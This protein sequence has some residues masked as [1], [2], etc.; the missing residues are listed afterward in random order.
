MAL[1]MLAAG[2][3]KGLIGG[4]SAKKAG[5]ALVKTKEPKIKKAVKEEVRTEKKASFTSVTEASYKKVSQQKRIS[6]SAFSPE[7]TQAKVDSKVTN[8]TLKTQLDN[9]IENTSKLDGVYKEQFKE[10]KDNAR[11]KDAALA[12]ERAER[13]ERK[14][15]TTPKKKLF[16]GVSLKGPTDIMD[17][18]GK[19]LLNTLLGGLA[20][21]T[22]NNLDKIG[23]LFNKFGGNLYLIFNGIRL[24]LFG[25][26]KFFTSILRLT[27]SIFKAGFKATGKL[28]KA[29]AKLLG[30]GL[31]KGFLKLGDAI[32]DFAR[33]TV[34]LIRRLA[35]KPP[36]RPRS[37]RRGGRNAARPGSRLSRN[38]RSSTASQ[39]ARKRY[40]QRYGPEAARRRFGGQTQRPSGQSSRLPRPK[41]KFLEKL[42]GR[43]T[44]GELKQASPVLKKVAKASKGIRIPILGPIL[45]AISSMLADEPPKQTMFKAVGTGLGEALG[46]L[47]PIPVVGT[48]IGGLVGEYGG[49]LL[50]TFLE[51]GGMSGVQAKMAQDWNNTLKAGADFKKY[52]EE[53]WNRYYASL[54][55]RNFGIGN[56]SKELPDPFFLFNPMKM[57]EN[58]ELLKN[59]LFP[60]ANENPSSSAQYG[61][62]DPITGQPSGGRNPRTGLPYSQSPG[63]SPTEP[64]D[65]PTSTTPTGTVSGGNADFWTLVAIASLEDSDAQGR[66]DV[67]QSIYN[68]AASGAYASTNIRKL[69]IA[70]GQYQPAYDYP[71][72]NP[73]GN[74]TNPEWLSIVDAQT[75]AAAT[76]KSVAFIEQ[77]A[78]DIMNP[79]L[80]KNARDFVGGRTDFTN[81]TK[82]DRRGEI[83]RQTGGKNNYFGW[84]WNY[85]GTV[86]GNVPDFGATQSPASVTPVTQ[87]AATPG[88]IT[89][90]QMQQKLREQQ[91]ATQAA[92][93]LGETPAQPQ[94][95]TTPNQPIPAIS[96][97]APYED[98]AD[99]VVPMPIPRTGDRGL[100]TMTRKTRP[101]MSTGAALIDVVNSYYT[102]QLMANLYKQG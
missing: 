56:F 65:T 22:L 45:V 85:S 41:N 16:G 86:Q 98:G 68:R 42:F 30:K 38:Q 99:L 25:L 43:K 19:F 36:L 67:A 37:G 52:M 4:K 70:N 12:K 82:T 71:R 62:P 77:A 24:G 35:G 97:S 87:P 46:T 18:I 54:P 58:I 17:M 75:A 83:Y 34:N 84:D 73:A 29:S 69:I 76:G 102:A 74:K 13:R 51:G 40:A 55:K 60:A 59:A 72:R 81:Y 95:S 15:E 6:A 100:Q 44:A 21:L 79:T 14:L 53:S 9:L 49:D 101:N 3:V 93:R 23:R 10:D 5:G 8:D 78:K 92:G 2:L 33:G 66:A 90:A 26:R 27:G 20:L 63:K 80:Q 94:I 91:A 88:G 50:Y 31:K 57:F 39:A 64:P 48:I 47:I 7:T 89:P 11:R 28:I 1:P 32:I 61:A 96:Q